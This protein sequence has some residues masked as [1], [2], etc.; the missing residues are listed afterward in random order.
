MSFR[1]G[2]R[3]YRTF[4]VSMLACLSFLALAIYGWGVEWSD[5]FTAMWVSGLLLVGLIVLAAIVGFAVYKIRRL[6]GRDPRLEDYDK[7]VNNA[8]DHR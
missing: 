2:Y 1:R 8:G 3:R 4:W 6:V 5:I 7:H